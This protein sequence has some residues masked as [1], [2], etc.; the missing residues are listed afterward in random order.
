MITLDGKTAKELGIL[1]KRESQRPILPNTRD[2]ILTIPGRHGAYDFGADLEPRMFDLQCTMIAK[3]STDLQKAVR[4]L[5]AFL[6]DQT[7]RPRTLE[8]RFDAEPEKW[9]MARYNGSLPIER[10]AYW[11]TFSLPLMAYD[12]YAYAKLEAYDQIYQYDAGF[13]YETGLY[14][15]NTLS[16]FVWTYSRHMSGQ[17]NFSPFQTP[18]IVEISGNVTNPKITNTA[19]G[20]WMAVNASIQNQVLRID[21]EKMTVTIDGINAMQYFSG[22]FIQ[23]VPDGNGLV[24]DGGKPN[25]Q[26]T[27][28]WKHKFL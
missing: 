5:A 9:Y 20:Q 26:V 15:P 19:N 12:P 2:R 17:T 11:G 21:G 8:F 10:V 3:N 4:K 6:M 27:F 28:L 24:F 25:A 14:Y 16:G 1:V 7:G 18:L 23:L 22:D 13:E